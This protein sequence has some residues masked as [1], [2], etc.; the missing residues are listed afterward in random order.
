M[1]KLTLFCLVDGENLSRAFSVKIQPDD[2]VDDLKEIIKT[3]KSHDFSDIDANSLTLWKVSIPIVAAESHKIISLDSVESKGELL[4]SDEVSEVYGDAPSKRTVHVLV[5]RSSLSQPDLHPEIAALRKQLSDVF[6]SSFS[7]G[8]V[9]KPEKKVAFSWCGIV[10]T[11]TLDDLKKNIFDLYPQYAH[12]DYLEIFVYNGQPKPELIRDNEDLRKILKVA[13]TTSKPRL[14]ISLETPTKSF[15]LWK[16]KDVCAE[17]N[18]SLSA[19][20]GLDVLPAFTDIEATPLV[21]E[22]QK[23]ML[24]Q[25]LDEVESMVDVLSLLGANEATRSMIVGAFLVKATRLF[26]EDL[27]LAAQRNLSG[28]RGNGEVDF[29]V[30][31]RKNDNLT[32]GVTEVKREDFKQGVAQNIVQ[33]ESALTTAKKR[34]RSPADVDGDEEEPMKARSYGIVTDAEKWLFLECTLHEDE[35]VTYRMSELDRSINYKTNWV[36]EAKYI[37]ERLVWLWSRMVDE[38]PARDSYSRKMSSSPSNR[39][40]NL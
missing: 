27:V 7:I 34:K 32:L 11:A 29:S 5:K 18:L 1:N 36:D 6:D 19:D 21:S 40:I 20:P 22:F 30:H 17:Y 13:K 4:P 33:L 10:D 15:S 9:V 14:T 12:D 23:K 31:S 2:T 3:K 37:L 28:R 25:L 8:I 35:S 24:A 38:I 26:K 39:R 16:F